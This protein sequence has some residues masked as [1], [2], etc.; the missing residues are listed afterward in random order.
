MAD[1][2]DVHPQAVAFEAQ[3]PAGLAR[4]IYWPT[5]DGA[6]GFHFAVESKVKV[7]W[8]RFLRHTYRPV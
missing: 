5:E 6:P 4:M 8:N 3:M 2:S 7:G 1:G